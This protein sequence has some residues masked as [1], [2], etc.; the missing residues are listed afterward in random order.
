MTFQSFTWKN[1][2]H[3]HND[4]FVGKKVVKGTAKLKKKN[5]HASSTIECK[6]EVQQQP[7]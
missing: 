5:L 7:K 4:P 3:Y 1:L 6:K 2:F